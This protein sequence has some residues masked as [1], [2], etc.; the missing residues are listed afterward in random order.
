MKNLWILFGRKMVSDKVAGREHYFFSLSVQ[1]IFED[2]EKK[3]SS[4]LPMAIM[5][6]FYI[7]GP[8]KDAL[9]AYQYLEELCN[10]DV[11]L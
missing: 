6:N 2:I 11:S 5:D 4:L 10:E 1:Y 9:D 7:V 3:F 8:T